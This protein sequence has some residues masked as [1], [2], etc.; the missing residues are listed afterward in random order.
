MKDGVLNDPRRMQVSIR[1][2]IECKAGEDTDKCLTAPQVSSLKAIYGGRER[3]KGRT[4]FPGYLP[5]G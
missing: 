5:G 1:Q 2:S 4:L 3:F